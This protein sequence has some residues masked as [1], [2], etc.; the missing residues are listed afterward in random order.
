MVN[1]FRSEMAQP[2]VGFGHS[3]GAN[4]LAMLSLGHPMLFSSL[5][6]IEPVISM[7][8]IRAMGTALTQQTLRRRAEWPSREAAEKTF[9]IAF[10]SWDPR[11]LERWNKYALYP[12]P[13]PGNEEEK[14]QPTR[15]TTGRFQE[16]T[17]IVRPG[18]IYSG[19]VEFTGKMTWVEE[20]TVLDNMIE[21]IPCSTFYICGAKG[22]SASPKMRSDWLARTG[23]GDHMGRKLRKRRVEDT[24]LPDVGHFAPLESPMACAESTS[25]WIDEDMKSWEEEQRSL[26]RTWGNLSAEEKEQRANDWMSELKAKM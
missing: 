7:D 1:V 17:G 21:F 4:L 18:F 3:M 10:Q 22:L 12:Y 14:A 20:V 11:V 9:K 8:A 19:S 13:G 6:L 26:N 24:V 16:L 2:I 15:L 23:T 5:V 25:R